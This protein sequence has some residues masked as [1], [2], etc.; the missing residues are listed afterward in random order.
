MRLPVHSYRLRRTAVAGQQL[1]NCYAEKSEERGPVLL[2]R[3][4]GIVLWSSLSGIGR[5][6]HVMAGVL[7]A[8]AGE[9][10]YS[11]SSTGV[12]TAIGAIAGGGQCWFADNGTEL[13]VGS[14]SGWY[15]WNGTTLAEITD[16]DFIARGARG[17]A[18]VDNYI[19]FIEPGS[20]RWF[21]SDLAAAT[22][23]DSLDFATAEGAPD[24]L[25][26]LAVDHREVMLFGE[27]TLELWYN[28]GASGFPFERSPDGFVEIGCAANQGVAKI[29]NSVFWL[30]NDLTI[31]RL[32][33]RTPERVSHH[34]VEEQLRSYATV[35]DCVARSWTWNGHLAVMFRFPSAGA[36]WVFDITTGEWHER[37]TY[38]YDGWNVVGVVEAY[39][40]VVVQNAAGDL[41]YF[42]DATHTEF[43]EIQRASW[44]YQPVYGS[45]ERLFHGRFEVVCET[46]VGLVTGQG[47][48]PRLTLEISNDGGRTWL[49]LPTRTLGGIGEYRTR[50]KWHRL[51]SSRDRV[52]RCSISDP[53]PLTVWDTVLEAA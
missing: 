51:G 16:A 8:V 52:Y 10:L 31:R 39:G 49:T 1:L 5:G 12:A 30:A 53:I 18:F 36:C 34:G 42:D 24:H 15:V 38:G 20:G 4:P 14:D 21:I 22:A 2:K 7:Y 28:S 6:L 44:T 43:G 47:S 41:G 11:I 23:Y 9:T 27:T 32:T 17:C 25:V 29:D 37:Q 13:V 45:N 19:S 33:G 26:S 50:V 46:G 35:S 3:A 40:K 48:D